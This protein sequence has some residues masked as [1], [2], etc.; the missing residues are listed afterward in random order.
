MDFPRRGSTRARLYDRLI[1]NVP[2]E[3]FVF[4]N[5]G[6]LEP[7]DDLAN[8][9]VDEP[10]TYAAN[11]V[12]RVVRGVAL[13][14]KVVVDVG[15]GRGGAAAWLARQ[16]CRRVIGLDFN[17]GNVAFCRRVHRDE[18]LSFV[19]GD[20]HDLPFAGGS[21]GVVFNLESSHCYPDR[22]RF[23]REVHRV[24]KGDGVF[25]YSDAVERE[26]GGLAARTAELEGSGFTI[27]EHADITKP[28]ADALF[29][30][31]E[32]HVKFFM[33]AIERNRAE[34]DALLRTLKGVTLGPF[35]GYVSGAL[36]YGV[37]RLARR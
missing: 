9:G 31:F 14:G 30:G 36:K 24:L 35:Y 10:F 2:D 8:L 4:M 17:A 26:S 25:C 20:A 28:V 19:R 33:S 7:H 18:R 29:V 6:Y 1:V 12:R 11:L 21:A 34:T 32:A 37:W 27:V 15:C 23:F 3:R 22:A 16:G 5:H 13:E